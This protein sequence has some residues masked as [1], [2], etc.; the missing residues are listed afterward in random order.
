VRS[1]VFV[2]VYLSVSNILLVLVCMCARVRKRARVRVQW[3]IQT[4]LVGGMIN[5]II[6]IFFPS[7]RG[8]EASE[9]ARSLASAVNREREALELKRVEGRSSGTGAVS[10][11]PENFLKFAFKIVCSSEYVN[12]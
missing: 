7:N 5:T 1:R 8:R 2:Y 3:R 12:A 9:C 11:L 4:F 10:P 6:C